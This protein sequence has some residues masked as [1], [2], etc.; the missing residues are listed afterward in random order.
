MDELSEFINTV[1]REPYSLIANN[2][3]HKSL[4]IRKR[5]RELGR[6]ADIVVC[7]SVVPIKKWHIITFNP[8]MYLRIDGNKV[9]VSLDPGHEAKYCK[10]SEKKLLFSVNVS[11][12]GR[13]VRNAFSHNPLLRRPVTESGHGQQ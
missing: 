7:I 1:Y 12:I 6:R 3:I 8:H 4:R 10:N 11:R 2:C 5:A 9:D 13:I